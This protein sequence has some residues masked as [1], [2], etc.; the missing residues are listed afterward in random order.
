MLKHSYESVC[1]KAESSSRR[2]IRTFG[3]STR[4]RAIPPAP[5]E[6]L[7][8]DCAVEGVEFEPASPERASD[9]QAWDTPRG[10]SRRVRRGLFFS[11][12]S[13]PCGQCESR[14]VCLC[15]G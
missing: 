3:L 4:F 7:V 10:G 14:S 1:P 2:L 6:G 11:L 15:H 12:R 9:P 8:R 13:L 5:C